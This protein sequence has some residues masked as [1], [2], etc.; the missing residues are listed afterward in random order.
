MNYPQE[1]SEPTK[2]H[3]KDKVYDCFYIEM[4][5][6][7]PARE[8][9]GGYVS[10]CL[11]YPQTSTVQELYRKIR[12]LLQGRLLIRSCPLTSRRNA[13]QFLVGDSI[14]VFCHSAY[15]IGRV[16]CA[17]SFPCHTIVSCVCVCVCVQNT[18][19]VH[20]VCVKYGHGA[21]V[22]GGHRPVVVYFGGYLFSVS[23]PISP[24]NI[25]RA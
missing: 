23:Q 8:G 4:P 11:C 14:F 6:T 24:A 17:R 12:K 19:Y 3:A 22:G 20:C 1:N 15:Y 16:V 25:M 2:H 7:C 5:A 9:C 18:V 10:I 13:R 21:R